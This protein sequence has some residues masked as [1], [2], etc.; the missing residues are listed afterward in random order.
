[1]EFALAALETHDYIPTFVD[2]PRGQI[3]K[4]VILEHCGLIDPENINHYLAAGG[5]EG[6]ARALS[7]SPEEVISEVK[8]SGLRG[9]GGAG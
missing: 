7:M 2:Y 9:R 1:M 6:L 3:E 8:A 4:K 5:Y